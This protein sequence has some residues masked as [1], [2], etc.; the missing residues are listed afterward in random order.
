MTPRRMLAG[1]TSLFLATVVT[2]FA[3]LRVNLSGS[4]PIG[5]YRVSGGPPV[6][7]AIVLACLPADVARFARA[8]GY[9]PN[10]RCPGRTAPIGKVVLAMAGDSVEVTAEGL[11]L[12]GRPVRNTKPLSVDAAGRSL[13]RFPDGTY[14]VGRDEVWLYSPYSKRSFDSRY[15]GPLA[16]SCIRSRVLRLWTV[17]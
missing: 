9:V 6:K 10:G 7:G 16:V 14:V 15:F 17:E 12:N 1:A 13:R 4:M 2:W 11:L 5:L 8:R 3:G